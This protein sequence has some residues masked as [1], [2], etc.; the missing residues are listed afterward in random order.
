MSVMDGLPWWVSP[1]Q[2]GDMPSFLHQ[3]KQQ[4]SSIETVITT[5]TTHWCDKKADDLTNGHGTHFNYILSSENA[6]QYYMTAI[7]LKQS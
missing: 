1:L 7:K 2:S 3:A 4:K 5:A 6:Y